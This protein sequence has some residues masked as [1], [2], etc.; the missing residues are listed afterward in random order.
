MSR[1]VCCCSV[2]CLCT[3]IPLRSVSLTPVNVE[4]SCLCTQLTLGKKEL[5]DALFDES[6]TVGAI[7]VVGGP[8]PGNVCP[9]R[10]PIPD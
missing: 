2:V 3:F 10:I 8:S 5:L 9:V 7:D 6:E 4:T 1:G